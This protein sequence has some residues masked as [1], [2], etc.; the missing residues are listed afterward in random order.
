MD[1]TT[2]LGILAALSV[3]ALAVSM[4]K[5]PLVFVSVPSLLIVVGGTLG[6][7]MAMITFPRFL[8]SFRIIGKAFTRHRHHTPL[9]LIDE[10]FDL[11]QIAR[12]RG[13][14]ALEDEE[15]PHPFLNKGVEMIV[16]GHTT[17]VIDQ[18]MSR[19]IDMAAYRHESGQRMLRGIYDVAPAMGM[20]GTLIGLVQMLGSLDDPSTIGPAMATALLTTL[21]GAIIAQAVALPIMEKLRLRAEEEEVEHALILEGVKG[22]QEGINP[23]V[24]RE[25]LLT[26]LPGRQRYLEEEDNA[27]S[28]AP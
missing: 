8:D 21:Y 1:K 20:I 14:L 13:A 28:E 7:T 2:L 19:E 16:D 3:V 18:A 11:A 24:L 12:K 25:L 27:A 9:D 17:E 4:G 22:I 6:I 26:F 5:N 23:K 15:I 10:V